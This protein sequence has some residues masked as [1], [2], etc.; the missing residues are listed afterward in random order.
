MNIFKLVYRNLIG[1]KNRF[2]FTLSGITMGIIALVVLISLGA[3]LQSQ[4]HNQA[5]DLGANMI[6]TAK[7]WC[8]YE[9]VKVLSGAQLPD[10]ILPEDLDKIE[11]IEG[12]ST[13]PYL[14]LGSAINNE[15]VSVTGVYIQQ[16]KDVRN[17]RIQIGSFPD[18]Q[19]DT[20]G[21]LAGYAIADRF[22]LSIGQVVRLRGQEFTV[23][24]IMEKHGTSDDAVLFIDLKTAMD[25]YETK[26]RVS[27]I[28]VQVED[29]KRLEYYTRLITDT[30]N[31]AVISDQQL[32]NSVLSVVNTVGTTLKI[33]AIIAILAA[34]FG[35]INTMITAIYERKKDIGI[36]KSI[37]SSNRTIFQIF[38]AE[39]AL[40][41]FIGGMIGLVVGN[42]I[43]YF[44]TPLI[45]QNEFTAFV[46][47]SSVSG[48]IAWQDMGIILAGSILVSALS[49]VYPA[50][51]AARLTPVEAI[52]Y[53]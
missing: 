19:K 25:V 18:P 16:L 30:A 15:L 6:V 17:W 49:G 26:G 21:I 34:S 32:L 20:R 13:Q 38:L 24:G 36:L 43:S 31:V 35:I 41:G 5:R 11:S 28:A 14:T 3:G 37:G 1:R 29:I 42:A 23:T 45:A 33:I 22:D 39:S 12:I 53:E 7:G 51:K 44:I 47:A 40:Y 4:I 46:R 8:A 48:T 2:V 9:Q 50:Y 27:Y 52:S 10:A